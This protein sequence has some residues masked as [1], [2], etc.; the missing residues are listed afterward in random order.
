[1][2][3]VKTLEAYEIA[4]LHNIPVHGS[5]QPRAACALTVTGPFPVSERGNKGQ[6]DDLKDKQQ[7]HLGGGEKI[8]SAFPMSLNSLSHA[9]VQGKDV[10]IGGGGALVSR[11]NEG[12]IKR[13][14][15]IC[16][17]GGGA[18]R[19]GSV[20]GGGRGKGDGVVV[21]SNSVTKGGGWR[22][23]AKTK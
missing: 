21:V 3:K 7:Q 10:V 2:G 19:V 8:I 11:L 6:G 9:K 16:C 17:G 20:G 23:C 18:Q 13:R 4:A 22:V 12:Q 5:Y 1:L 15:V 14:K